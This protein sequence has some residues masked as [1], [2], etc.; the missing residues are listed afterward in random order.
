MRLFLK[1]EINIHI[2]CYAK[3]VAKVF[4]AILIKVMKTL[5]KS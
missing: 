2:L 1:G 5:T 3:F 4:I